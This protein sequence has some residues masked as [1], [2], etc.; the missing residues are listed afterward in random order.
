MRVR[1]ICWRAWDYKPAY[2]NLKT[3]IDRVTT[4]KLAS[5]VGYDLSGRRVTNPGKGVYIINDKKVL[6]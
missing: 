5:H 3:G 2:N 6:K 1:T 4:S